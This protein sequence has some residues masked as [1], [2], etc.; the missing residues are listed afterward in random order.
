MS[1]DNADKEALISSLRK[2]YQKLNA[3]PA[4]YDF[5]QPAMISHAKDYANDM[6]RLKKYAG[7]V[8]NARIMQMLSSTFMK[9]WFSLDQYSYGV[10][11][12]NPYALLQS[13]RFQMECFA[14]VYSTIA[15]VRANSGNYTSGFF[16]RVVAV[17]EALVN[18]TYGTRS[19]DVLKV[20]EELSPSRLRAVTTPLVSAL[21]E[22]TSP[23]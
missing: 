14:L 1:A 4:E 13:T 20:F 12:G 11:K 23:S 22:T 17:D 21:G 9:T 16:K 8:I 3:S 6:A 18:A 15:V 7:S 2:T 10:E 19:E 5:M